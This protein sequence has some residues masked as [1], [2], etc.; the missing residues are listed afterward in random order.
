MELLTQMD[1]FEQSVNVKVIMATNRA[2]TLDPALLRPGRLDRKIEFPLP[3]RRQKRLVFATCTGKM[4]IASDVDLEDYVFRSDRI[5]AS[6]ISAI[7][8]T[9]GCRCAIEQIR[10]YPAR[11]CARV[12]RG[13]EEEHG[14]VRVLQVSGRPGAAEGKKSAR[15]ESAPTCLC[16]I[17]T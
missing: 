14:R 13:G 15:V 5:S 16:P 10:R 3:D 2:D 1:G 9:A 17:T 8:Q 4:S 11:L 6:E 12:P 7:C